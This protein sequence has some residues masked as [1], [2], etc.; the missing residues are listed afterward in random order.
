MTY[1]VSLCFI[2]AIAGLMYILVT[3]LGPETQDAWDAR[4]KKTLFYCACGYLVLLNFTC[5]S[6]WAL[7]HIATS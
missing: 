5:V 6:A 3:E 1:L 4:E 2:L 7:Y